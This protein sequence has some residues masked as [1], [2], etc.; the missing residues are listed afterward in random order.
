MLCTSPCDLTA[1][2][3]T[4]ESCLTSLHTWFCHNRLGLNSSKSESILFGTSTRLRN[5]PPLTGVN[6]AGTVVPLSDKIVTLRVTLDSNLT[7]FN[8]ISNTCRSAYYHIRALRHIRRSLTD[9][10]ARTVVASLVHSRIDY[11]N[12]L[13]HGSTNIKK[14]QQLQ[15]TAARIVLPHLSKRPSTSLLHELHWLPV[16]S[17][18]IYKLACLTYNSLST[19]LL[20]TSPSPRD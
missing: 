18:I 17:K 19:C 4:L 7:L 14:L 1:N 9:D 6:I 5:F 10:M 12:S 2:L 13:V 16:H 8:H 11:T 3:N 15:N 20:Y